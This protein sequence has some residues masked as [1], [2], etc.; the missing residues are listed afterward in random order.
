MLHNR[1]GARL[2][3]TYFDLGSRM[4]DLDFDINLEHDGASVRVT[5]EIDKDT[6]EALVAA[7]LWRVSQV[8]AETEGADE[9]WMHS[10][11]E[12]QV[13]GF[14]SESH[15]KFVWERGFS[16]PHYPERLRSRF[17]KHGTSTTI[18]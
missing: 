12:R 17:A 13:Q 9:D 4:H 16:D 14:E 8:F 5:L 3:R 11:L 15:L 2:I 1:P 10:V 7:A 18:N 6:D